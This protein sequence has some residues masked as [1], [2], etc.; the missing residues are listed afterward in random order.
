M[1]TNIELP[2]YEELFGDLDFKKGDDARSVY[3]PA[4]YLA[5]LLQLLDDEFQA[6]QNPVFQR[7][8]DIKSIILNSEN[9][10][11]LTPYLSIVN[12]ILES[13]IQGDTYE[14]LKA[15]QYPF[16]LPFNLENEK[17]KQVLTHLDIRPSQLYK[18]FANR[19]SLKQETIAREHLGLSHE[20]MEVILKPSSSNALKARYGHSGTFKALQKVETYLEATGLKGPELRELIYQNLSEEEKEAKMAAKF[21]VNQ[22]F[23]GYAVLDSKE[24]SITLQNGS[25]IPQAWMDRAQRFI[26]LAKKIKMSFRDLD[27]I[28]RTCCDN[29]LD[30]EAIKKIAVITHF[31][32]THELSI[33]RVCALFGNLNTLGYGYEEKPADLFNYIFNV[34]YTP[35]DRYYIAV[36]PLLPKQYSDKG[37]KELSFS[38]KLLDEH[39]KPFRKRL[40]RALHLTDKNLTYI[41]E[42]F[43]E[44]EL[45]EN[46]WSDPQQQLHLLTVL[47]RLSQ[48]LTTFDLSPKQL[49]S[50]FDLLDR[51]PS[52]KTRSN[53]E[54]L[55]EYAPSGASC[56]EIL[57]D[58]E[59]TA[60]M[61]LIQLLATVTKWMQANDFNTE[62]LTAI[63]TGKAK[64]EKEASS[65]KEEKIQF[66]N[67]LYQQF[68]ISAADSK[69]FTG[70]I[71]DEREAQVIYRNLQS[72]GQQLI[73]EADHRLLRFNSAKAKSFGFEAVNQLD[74]IKKE[75]FKGLGIEEKLSDKIFNHLVFRGYLST[76]GM[77]QKDK[78]PAKVED[79]KLETDFS[80]HK[81][82][83]F[84][85]IHELYLEEAKNHLPP[86]EYDYEENPSEEYDSDDYD[87]DYEDE[88]DYAP[89]QELSPKEKVAVEF[90]LFPSDF[91][92]LELTELERS[93]LYDNLIFNGYIDEDGNVLEAHFCAS[94]AKIKAFKIQV[95]LHAHA[96][97]IFQAIKAQLGGFKQ[98]SLTL[99]EAIF[100]EISFSATELEN[101][102]EN[103]KFNDYLKPDN[104]YSDKAALLNLE[105]KDFN[106]SL[107]FYPLRHK[108]LGAIKEQIEAFRFNFYH[109]STEKLSNIADE[110]ISCQ[111]Y[112]YVQDHCLENSRVKES[113]KS[114]F[115]DLS[116]T[117]S[118]DL[119]KPFTQ[120]ASATVFQ[121]LNAILSASDTYKLTH[122]A[123]E[124]MQFEPEERGELFSLLTEMGS[125]HAHG[126]IA[127]DK[128]AYFLK[129]ENA[130]KFSVEFFEDFSKDLFFV[131]HKIAKDTDQAIREIEAKLEN[132]SEQQ[133]SLLFSAL[134]ENL[135]VET[136]TVQILLENILRKPAFIVEEFMLPVL[137]VV[138]NQ[139]I[140]TQEPCNNAFN[141]A[142]RRL[143]QLAKLVNQLKLSATETE[144][145]FND[146][147]L[148]EKFPEKL[149]L[150]EGVN[151]FDT[152]LEGSDEVIYLFSGANYFIYH[153][154][155]YELL[156]LD[157]EDE[158]LE[159]FI[160]DREH[161]RERLEKPN[162]VQEF[163]NAGESVPKVDA[164]FTDTKGNA[165]VIVG[166]Q[167]YFKENGKHRWT[168]KEHEWGKIESN[169][170]LPERINAAFQDEDGKTYFFSGDQYIRYSDGFLNIDQGYPKKIVGNWK[171][172]GI[173][174]LLPS[175]FQISIDAA[176][177]DKEKR[178]YLFKD[179]EFIGSGDLK[180]ARPIKE[181]WGKVRNNFG[182]A[183]KI[184]A[185]YRDEHY[186]YLYAGDQV[187]AYLDCLEN[188][189]VYVREGFPKTIEAHIPNL[190]GTFQNSI[191]A[192]F[193]GADG[194]IHLFKGNEAVSF[195]S[196]AASISANK[197]KDHWGI[198]QNDIWDQGLV[199][200]AFVGLDGK[201]YLFS[202]EQYIRYSG[203]SYK[204]VDEGY[205]RTIQDDWGGLKKVDAA[206]VL[207]GKTYL[208]EKIG[209]N[210]QKY[211]RYSSN[212]YSTP[213]ED[214]PQASGDNWLSLPFALV[215]ED[216][217]FANIDAVFN[218]ANGRTFLFKKDKFV[219][220]DNNHR[221]WSE[222]EAIE[223]RWDS[224]TFSSVDAA[225]TGKDGKTYLFSGEQYL[226]YS[227]KNFSKVDDRFPNPTNSYWG[228]I[229]NNIAETGKVDAAVILES[230]E[231]I[232]DQE[233]KTQHTYL[234]SGKQFFRYKDGQ[235]SQVE[236]GYPK[237]I[238]SSLK[239]EPRFKHL[240]V[241]IQEGVDA[242]FADHRNVYL[243]KGEHYHVLA[244]QTDISYPYTTAPKAST[245]FL[246]DGSLYLEEDAQWFKYASIESNTGWRTPKLPAVLRDVPEHFKT[247]LNAVL[248]GTDQNTYLF[249]DEEVYNVSL[250]RS[251]PLFEE[252]GRVKNNIYIDD[253]VDAALL[254]RD[255]K[256][257][258]FSGDQY[259]QYDDELANYD[260]AVTEWLPKPIHTYWGGL[261]SI[262]L[263]FVEDEKTFLFEKP[264]EEGNFRYLCYTGNDYS[265]P[266]E[267][268]PQT[269]N[270]DFWNIPEQYV[271]E[272]F[273]KVDSLLVDEDNMLL[274]SGENFLQFNFEEKVWAYPRPLDRIW[275]DI[276]LD[277]DDFT[278]V[279]SVFKGVDGALYFFSKNHYVRYE[280]GAFSAPAPINESWGITE[281][282]FID[283]AAGSKVDA[284]FVY[285]NKTTFLFS[286][287][288]YVR[289]S[290]SDYRYVDPGYPK[291]IV[292]DLLKEEAFTNVAE[293]FENA[294]AVLEEQGETVL[295]DAIVAN[296]N[297]IFILSGKEWHVASQGTACQ[298]KINHLGKV[299]NIVQEE[300]R[301]DAAFVKDSGEVFLI[302]GDQ[303]LRY[304]EGN[305][306]YV[307]DGY[308]KNIASAL[309]SELGLT[310]LP[311]KFEYDLDAIF[312]G[313][314][315]N[316]NFFKGADYFNS[317]SGRVQS[318]AETL[319]RAT[320]PFF[321]DTENR[322]IDAAFVSPNGKFYLFKGEQFL[323][324][325]NPEQEYADEGYPKP[326][327]DHWG[328]IP[329]HFETGF[330]SGFVFEGKTYFVKDEAYIRY[331]DAQYH[332]MDSIY[333]QKFAY[334]WGEWNDLLL[335]D[336]RTIA[337]YKELQ[338]NYRSEEHSLTDLL[339]PGKG[340]ITNPYE[341]IAEI[342]GWDLEELRWLKRNN[343]FLS[344]DNPFETDFNLELILKMYEV[345]NLSGQ[346]GIDPASLYKA[347]KNLYSSQGDPKK[348]SEELYAALGLSLSEKDWEILSGQ[349]R[350]GLNLV[351][352]DALVSYVINED[353]AVQTP[354]E[355]YEKLLIDVQMGS[356]ASTSRIKEAI[357]AVQLYMHRYFLN[358]EQG[359]LKGNDDAEVRKTLKERWKWLK[360]YRVW[361]A[362]RKVFLYPEN[363]IRPELRDD[364]TPAFQTFESDLLQAEITE[365]AVEK[366]YK[367]YLDE[368]T[369]VS[370]LSIAGGYVYDEPGSSK[371][372]KN[373]ILFGH[374]KTSPKRYY[375]RQAR[376]PQGS[377]VW[378]AWLPVNVQIDTE[379]VYPV[380]AFGR[381][382]VFW[383]RSEAIIED[384]E[385]T[386]ITVKASGDNQ[387][388]TNKNASNHVIRINYAFYDL[389]KEWVQVQTLAGEISNIKQP[390]EIELFVENSENLEAQSGD[391]GK[392]ENIV[393]N[394]TFKQGG[395]NSRIIRSFSL[396]PEL[397]SQSTSRHFIQNQGHFIF[398][399]LFQEPQISSASVTMLNT[400]EKS[401]EVPW[402]SFD[403]KGGSFLCKPAIPPI[404]EK[405]WPL[406]ISDNP[407]FP[408]WDQIDA[409]LHVPDG[410]SFFFN[411][412]K[413]VFVRSDK[414]ETE[415]PIT[416]R[417]AFPVIDAAYVQGDKAFLIRK[418]KIAR[419]SFSG[420]ALA[421]EPDVGYPQTYKLPGA[422]NQ[423]HSAFSIEYEGEYRIYLIGDNGVL[424]YTRSE[425]KLF[426]NVTYLNHSANEIIKDL[427]FE[428]NFTIFSLART[429]ITAAYYRPALKTLSLELEETT[430]FTLVGGGST[431]RKSFRVMDYNLETK[432]TSS[433][434]RGSAINLV[435]VRPNGAL[436]VSGG[437]SHDAAFV[438]EFKGKK[439]F[440]LFKG[441][442]FIQTDTI[443][444]KIS[445]F[446]FNNPKKISEEFSNKV[447]ASF[448]LDGETH[449]W[450]KDKYFSLRNTQEPNDNSFFNLRSINGNW[451]NIPLELRSGFDGSLNTGKNL[452]LFK[453]KHFISYDLENPHA[454]KPYQSVE[455][456][457]EIIR[458]TAST[459]YKI[460]Q[461]LFSGGIPAMLSLATQEEDELPA[462]SRDLSSP[463]TIR[464]KDKVTSMPV[465]SHL[466]FFGANG[467]YYWEM[468]FHAPLLIAQSFNTE[469]KFEEAKTW[470][471][472]MYDPTEVTDYW[473]FLPFL[474]IDVRALRGSIAA[475]LEE[476]Q[477]LASAI[478]V[479]YNG[480]KQSLTDLLDFLN[481]IS[482]TD[483]KEATELIQQLKDYRT[484]SATSATLQE[485]LSLVA[486]LPVR[487]APRNTNAEL[488]AYL[489]DPFDPHAIA[490]LRYVAYQKAVVMHYIDN[491]KDWGDMYFR[492][493]TGESID[494][495]RMLYLLAY[496]LLGDRPENLGQLVL[497]E[498]ATLEDLK[499][500]PNYDFLLELED[501]LDTDKLVQN[502]LK[503]IPFTGPRPILISGRPNSKGPAR[504]FNPFTNFPRPILVAQPD[505]PLAAQVH[506]SVSDPYFFIP[507]NGLIGDYWNQIEDRLYKIR[508]CLNIDGVQQALP[509]FQPPLDPMALVQSTGAGSS[510]G[511]AA[512]QSPVAVPHYRFNF[513]MLK[514]Q[515]LVFTLTRFAGELLGALEK[516]DSEALGALQSKQER[517]I[518]NM[519]EQIKEAQLG[520]IEES[521]N[522]LRESKANAIKRK[523]H[524]DHLISEGLLALEKG[525]IGMMA[526]GAVLQAISAGLNVAS[527]GG[528][529][530]PDVLAGPFIMGVKYG[531]SNAGAA[532]S[533]WAQA[534]EVA[535]ESSSM[536]G[537]VLG[538][539]AQHKRMEQDW[540]IQ[541]KIAESDELELEAQIAST[542]WRKKAAQREIL[543]HKKEV[544]H[545]E[546]ISRFMKEKFSNEELYRW[547]SSKLSGLYHQ[548]YKFAYDMAKGAEKAFQFERGLKESE[549]NYIHPVYWNSQKKGLLAGESLST[550]LNRMEKAYIEQNSR[551]LEICK[552]ISLLEL[553]PVAFLELK[554]K[555]VCEFALNE[556]LFDYDFPG[557]YR[558]QVKTIALTF[559]IGGGQSVMATLTQLNHKTVLEPDTKAVKFLLD[560]K[561]L[562]PEGIRSDWRAQ[563]QVAL[564][565]H[566]EYEK[567]NGLFELRFDSDRYLPFEGTGAV[568]TWRL[569]LNGKKGSYNVNDILEVT[570]NL[571]YTAK[572]AG[573]AFGEAV[574]GMLK[575]YR[576]VRFFDMHFDFPAQWNEFVANE[577]D[578]LV[579]PVSRDLFPNMRGSK[580]EGIFS[581]YDLVQDGP[582][583]VILEAG[584]SLPLPDGK[585]VATTGLSISGPGRDFELRIKGDK[586]NL[587]NLQFAIS[588][589]ANP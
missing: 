232:D 138:D 361:E 104:S 402:F 215:Q 427:G 563:Q 93:E 231:I 409:A 367:K 439:S 319:Q 503:P 177:Q 489:N 35:A 87:N 413:A 50:L 561:G 2:S 29:V 262:A 570:I 355:L 254:G 100:E 432:K 323:R 536:F 186:T 66:L 287:N 522:A 446:R 67:D 384:V 147:D 182:K 252:W 9:T 89:H 129:I 431:P 194:K 520:E 198:V 576:T 172:E 304:S 27:V 81:E 209:N 47:F 213:D 240:M 80:D 301:V 497:P 305:Y 199:D 141:Y 349:L 216:Y 282:N 465:S 564:S 513:M 253:T 256:T 95:D 528:S 314:E 72:S 341:A 108:I 48:I 389:N 508:Q 68:Q 97:S 298:G 123:L 350:D 417:W 337:K 352:R 162:T 99:N 572:Q 329:I 106:L 207:D 357:A 549:V 247:G 7:R 295:V 44:K 197:T 364:K 312:R 527:S 401:S 28:L 578:E 269:A 142:Y 58:K 368:Y 237:Y 120:S 36:T 200:A 243:F 494:E 297:S 306:D 462:F 339:H 62:G 255:G 165:W 210:Q 82:A 335:G 18:L 551:D 167:Y 196:G 134:Q 218:D 345:F 375:Y 351:K 318:V 482:D 136:E 556:A 258:L 394:C 260:N 398:R 271:K 454:P 448:T 281:N 101:L 41:V 366:V 371:Q 242:A 543:I 469:Q 76:Q 250:N 309:P 523:E 184:D 411:N 302:A 155:N 128:L 531:G 23:N 75:D 316:Y 74:I 405:A 428:S 406:N 475:R 356:C 580:I 396:T 444:T 372:V 55:I 582:M 420:K 519:T 569:E 423:V 500:T 20:E 476:E 204:W 333:P 83:I 340:Q 300:N 88:D 190:P 105:V 407:S 61:W 12:E 344:V 464:V 468:F 98:D 42:Y 380:F 378:G 365:A 187:T 382:F 26:R 307:D 21:F 450:S 110:I 485:L 211:V 234:F 296:Q 463:T 171:N 283:Q 115:Q 453:G 228:R 168:R 338:D 516:K 388:I 348:A 293:E 119:G 79:F 539:F 205:P 474:A 435:Y 63:L 132:L 320:I 303:Y 103:L 581:K 559:D 467:I 504:P 84:K 69:L 174:H 336:L 562:Q 233:I 225:F 391:L 327:K 229:K 185:A 183:S 537:E 107:Q 299:R 291:E 369:E 542:E 117:E 14:V 517:I 441:E 161:L 359:D 112:Q 525:Q 202:G 235:Y 34:A 170:E 270:F 268:F 96:G 277:H 144:V 249:K 477:V 49:F 238:A 160:E 257:Y 285:Q 135:G 387:T 552:N 121:T 245:A 248:N 73:S 415:A 221:W 114:Y 224:I 455:A 313:G 501:A 64:D 416:S 393:I 472:Y 483:E 471:E 473:K 381:I 510:L 92:A 65:Q 437:T 130:L 326:I 377:P 460:N 583:N 241:E 70:D 565:H 343:A 424:R 408:Q 59:P 429:R 373:L 491:L 589:T 6:E 529:M 567:N 288:Q 159:A 403:H 421:A 149:A 588:Y 533:S 573:K 574:K 546:A 208:Y 264:D 515:D 60:A 31:H 189:K 11:S 37:Y 534:S 219:Y 392:H 203:E 459:A 325:D 538:V 91:E 17:V 24:E 195:E 395:S 116:N 374:T 492:Q 363:Y 267:G 289:Y 164:S 426:D 236:S 575:P 222:P 111:V 509:L 547:F 78:F 331:S 45:G 553:D 383:A 230:R 179:G 53:F 188:D 346:A 449:I 332:Y 521:L 156:S 412:E 535:G 579:L 16:K 362:N 152:L 272:G 4:A 275:E 532:L 10:F 124:E 246:E 90:S 436:V 544:E 251:Y 456:P 493:Y 131:L 442:E 540:E 217:Q 496:N 443:P 347:W 157:T 511:A 259:V 376:F 486:Q 239:E 322:S 451:G 113:K 86:Q 169:F 554:T 126:T 56:C 292:G 1:S 244:D 280:D 433:R 214:Y 153:A 414:L 206:F 560:P 102:L 140:I 22:G 125:I 127:E 286:G 274:I 514:A 358:L 315:N 85:I 145:V 220:F 201:T 278:Y 499:N 151:H 3:S 430:F 397:Y 550:D 43:E 173:N 71:F 495:A 484:L 324:Y 137:S 5:D 39:N 518:L 512:L 317:A 330:D 191:S 447:S 261:S 334:R 481:T 488:E 266:D 13:K 328:D 587:R 143:Q 386:K 284:A 541:L 422:I 166:S 227:G 466:D 400:T 148:V 8:E 176:F 571:K 342:F 223:T 25:D 308:P 273:T 586:A 418:D 419:Y 530:A 180:T 354:R 557:H 158:E 311:E 15:A 480:Q 445:E 558:R 440:F 404:G 526:A 399:S 360:S 175:T 487:L 146:Q 33:A 192:S 310:Q 52:I 545:H 524:Y 181:M 294:V 577:E 425:D 139:D 54:V 568:S 548:T 122:A 30:V 290:G 109:L 498:E 265:Q 118:F 458:L 410:H 193:K 566:E 46:L 507:E 353:D 279:K 370:R 506:H 555:G 263:A 385:E 434:S 276:P 438:A 379:K 163:L 77:V 478:E 94:E 38:G 40:S 584:D 51:D 150:P 585:F 154:K 390:S 178:S 479:E 57:L 32:Q 461:R 212:D 502:T 321:P 470:Y 505:S 457:Y 452:F 19:D 226:R 133:Q 490:N